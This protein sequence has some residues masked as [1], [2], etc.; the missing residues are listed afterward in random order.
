[1]RRRIPHEAEL[2]FGGIERAQARKPREQLDTLAEAAAQREPLERAAAAD[3]TSVSMVERTPPR[4]RNDSVGIASS[5]IVGGST[6]AISAPCPEHL[7][8]AQAR[9]TREQRPCPRIGPI[10][11]RHREALE[12]AEQRRLE[13]PA[14]AVFADA[15]VEPERAQLRERGRADDPL[16]HAMIEVMRLGAELDD[17]RPRSRAMPGCASSRS[18]PSSVEPGDHERRR[19]RCALERERRRVRAFNLD[20]VDEAAPEHAAPG[21][22][23]ELRP[24]DPVRA[25]QLALAVP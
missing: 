24:R 22:P 3:S 25:D 14:H 11:A 18:T 19:E 10:E 21:D 15:C 20:R 23:V 1:M 5:T 13:E 9:R 7:E 8:R 12:P 6:A 17:V 4:A 2:T 16:D